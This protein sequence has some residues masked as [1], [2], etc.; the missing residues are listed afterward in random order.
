MTLTGMD[1]VIA[2]ICIAFLAVQAGF[3]GIITIIGVKA[4]VPYILS[5][6]TLGVVQCL[7]VKSYRKHRHEYR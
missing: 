6:I 4:G 7:M 1:I 2:G 5:I 3:V